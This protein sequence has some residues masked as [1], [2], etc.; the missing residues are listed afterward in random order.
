MIRNWRSLITG[1][2]F[3]R[4]LQLRASKAGLR[5]VWWVVTNFGETMILCFR[6]RNLL[7]M[8]CYQ[9]WRNCFSTF[10]REIFG[11]CLSQ[12][13]TELRFVRGKCEFISP[14]ERIIICHPHRLV[15]MQLGHLMSS[16]C[17]IHPEVCSL[18]SPI[19]FCLLVC[20]FHY[21]Q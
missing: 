7:L 1:F 13:S 18:V 9:L 12:K 5:Q 6:Q 8:G 20:S 17:L 16:S 3:I 14:C 11:S 15:V 2:R 10:I 4:V 21:G 19:S